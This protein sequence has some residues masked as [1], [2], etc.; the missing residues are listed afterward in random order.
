MRLSSTALAAAPSL[1]LSRRGLLLG[2]T[3][4]VP[5]AL[6][7]CESLGPRVDATIKGLVEYGQAL[8]TGL[9]SMWAQLQTLPQVQ[10]LSLET[11]TVISTSGKAVGDL[12]AALSGVQSVAAAQPI[13]AK[14]ATY[15]QAALG[16]LGG[17]SGM[18][19][20]VVSL[21]AAAQIVL[22]VLQSLVGLAVATMG[23]V[24][25][26]AQAKAILLAAPAS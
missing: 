24:Q 23:Q 26:A 5:L 25:A 2:T 6:G 7:A 13:V 11:K 17:I 18:P 16:A 3:A 12:L 8:Y 21:I 10:A 22:P 9:K 20:T 1:A 4:C 19:G 14:L 15:A